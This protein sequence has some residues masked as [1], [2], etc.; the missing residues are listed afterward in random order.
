MDSVTSLGT[1]GN[2]ATGSTGFAAPGETSIGAP[3][4]TANGLTTAFS[5]VA[6]D[7]VAGDTNG[8][9]DVFVRGS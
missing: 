6:S 7:L 3:A 2:D 1:S 8:F 5:S 9:Y 4:I